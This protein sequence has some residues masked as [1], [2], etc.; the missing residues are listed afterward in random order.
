MGS[1]CNASYYG[2]TQRYVFVE[3][4]EHFGITPLT[5]TFVK[6]PKKSPIFDN[7][8]L[9]DHKASFD[10]LSTIFRYFQKKIMHL[11]HNWRNICKNHMLSQFWTKIFTDFPWNCSIEVVCN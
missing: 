10:N 2:K 9:D 1:W 8:L 5:C 11:Y 4:S 3:A 7:M 6:T